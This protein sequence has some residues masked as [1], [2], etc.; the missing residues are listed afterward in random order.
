MMTGGG[1]RVKKKKPSLPVRLPLAPALAAGDDPLSITICF[2]DKAAGVEEIQ[3]FRLQK[4]PA[5]FKAGKF[6]DQD[7]TPDAFALYRH[8]FYSYLPIFILQST[9]LGGGPAAVGKG[10]NLDPVNF[11][12]GG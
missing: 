6:S 8:L 12:P 4:T 3:A 1:G 2:P 5:I 11:V 9:G 10:G 7:P